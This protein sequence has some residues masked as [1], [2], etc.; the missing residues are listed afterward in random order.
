MKSDAAIYLFQQARAVACNLRGITVT[1]PWYFEGG[2]ITKAGSIV[3]HRHTMQ[4]VLQG[5][6]EAG[7]QCPS[8][9]GGGH[10]TQSREG[11]VRQGERTLT[12]GKG[13]CTD[14]AAAAAV[15][16]LKVANAS[17]YLARVEILSTGWHAF[18]LVNRQGSLKAC[19]RWGEG[20]FVLDIWYQNQFPMNQVSGAFW[21]S[22]H[23]HPT[24]KNIV[25]ARHCLRV[26]VVFQKGFGD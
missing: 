6:R 3:E 7:G 11:W 21:V 17:K 2:N 10:I 22:D 19:E 16:F 14:C 9:L 4:A 5:I 13:V 15:R 1:D 25:D 24:M 20:A 26:E 23:T 8:L 12:L 18:V